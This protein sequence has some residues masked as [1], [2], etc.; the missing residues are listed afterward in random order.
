MATVNVQARGYYKKT[1]LCRRNVARKNRVSHNT[2]T[3]LSASQKM[4]SKNKQI[5]K[6][7]EK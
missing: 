6:Y 7:R 4:F 2:C 3:V 1:V 5:N